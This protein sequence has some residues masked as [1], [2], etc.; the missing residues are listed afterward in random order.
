MLTTLDT[1]LVQLSEQTLADKKTKDTYEASY[2]RVL[3]EVQEK[4]REPK[5]APRPANLPKSTMTE[6]GRAFKEAHEKQMREK[7]EKERAA[8]EAKEKAKAK[9]KEDE[10]VKEDEKDKDKENAD[11]MDVEDDAGP[12]GAAVAG[13]SGAGASRGQSKSGK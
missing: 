7:E 8:K 2:Q 9:A 6:A 10:K 4:L 1:K 13:G 12:S 5:I 11:A 3:H